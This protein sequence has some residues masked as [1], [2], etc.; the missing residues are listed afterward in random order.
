MT[1]STD[2]Q[3]N[4]NSQPSQKSFVTSYEEYLSRYL[5]NDVSADDQKTSDIGSRLALSTIDE[6]RKATA[7]ST[8][9]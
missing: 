6:V 7:Y 8:K 5:Q 3:K 9:K 1:S 2:D 4:N